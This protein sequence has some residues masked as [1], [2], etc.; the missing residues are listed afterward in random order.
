MPAT[1]AV[2]LRALACIAGLGGAATCGPVQVPRQL[3][4]AGA[5]AGRYAPAQAPKPPAPRVFPLAR[6]PGIARRLEAQGVDVYEIDLD[7]GQYLYATF[8][9]RG[10][11]VLVAV[12]GPG[13]P[14]LFEVDGP[15]GTRGKERVHLV[16]ERGGRY[17]LAVRARRTDAA[18]VYVVRLETLRPATVRD[19]RRAAAERCFYEA[20]A[21]KGV[22]PRFWEG[23]ARF[24]QAARLFRALGAG[25]R[26][27]EALYRLGRMYFDGG[28]HGEAL[29]ALQSA[30]ELFAVA[31]DP[32]RLASSD[33]SIGRCY[34]ASGRFR[35]AEQAFLRAAAEWRQA[36]EPAALAETLVNLGDLRTY[37]GMARQALAVY[38]QAAELRRLSRDAAGEAE[39]ETHLGSALRL[40]GDLDRALVELGRGLELSQ[41]VG[42][43]QRTGLLSQIGDVFIAAKEPHR[44]LACFTQALG[45]LHGD[46]DPESRAAILQ[47]LG[48]AYRLL[49]DFGQSRAAYDKALTIVQSTGNR[50]AEAMTWLNL[51][52]A[53]SS[54][55]QPRQ[56]S[57]CYQHALWL[58]RQTGYRQAEALAL[59]GIATA[60]RDTG[61]PI[62]AVGHG[63]AALRL[64][65][66]LRAAASRPDLQ[67]TYLAINENY[68]GFL[69][70]TLMQLHRIMPG[71]GYELRAFQCSEQWR[72]RGLLDALVARRE[73]CRLP[74]AAA[75]QLDAERRRLNL[76]I[77]GKDLELRRPRA[78]AAGAAEVERQLRALWDRTQDVEEL[79]RQ[80]AP[81]HGSIPA[82]LA[83][84]R[85]KLLDD[86]TVLL[87]YY[88]GTSKSYLWAA[89]SDSIAGFELPA[90]GDL[91]S[92]AL[93]TYD[94]LSQ[95]RQ[96][97]GKEGR[98]GPAARLSQVLL[99]QIAARL[100]DR[101]LVIVADGVL[102]YI[103]FAALPD[104]RD[105]DVPLMLHHEIVYV[106]SLAV[107]SELCAREH[108]KQEQHP[109]GLIAILADPVFGPKDERAR[110]SRVVSA[111]LDPLVA[112]LPRMPY[113]RVEADGIAAL[114]GGKGVLE[115]LGFEADRDLVTGGRL[116]RYRDLHFVTH[117]TLR[118]DHPELSGL[119]LSQLDAA[120]RAHYG[121]LRADEI[122][123][124]D[125]PVD[126][127]VLS[128]CKTAVGR[129]LAGEGMVGLPQGFMI[130]GARRVLVS[131]WNVGDRSTAEL[132]LHFYQ[133]LLVDHLG[134]GAAL[135]AAQCAMW[136][137][138]SRRAPY[139]WAGFV[140]QGD[141]R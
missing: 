10:I 81:P 134:P 62:G 69:V 83:V 68:F 14:A 136:R 124:L 121:W 41:A 116:R 82:P 131:L 71:H 120:G 126:L 115:A 79:L 36:R 91:E 132:M 78:G 30:R 110:R 7:A 32:F 138:P 48:I 77:A 70:G 86:H 35:L 128:A 139:C 42:A 46:E 45:L 57:A 11:D 98:S 133:G 75:A 99:G 84:L 113:A 58:A 25:H 26:Q 111:Q 73:R 107:L 54:M 38:R 90:R 40:L 118:T 28:R 106:P 63:D 13:S 23:V 19:R 31:G 123:A 16:A 20:L 108:D 87:E 55:Q 96:P 130:A 6:G 103:P 15:Y 80:Q 59:L 140:L 5:A 85:H 18:G 76:R 21:I 66:A 4:A 34:G 109:Q 44:A 9:Q 72:A 49:G 2:A 56:A 92:L 125:L 53:I 22:R 50:R 88:L 94:A 137:D 74:R 104:P 89:T 47:G 100:S 8:D 101:R 135:R 67:A 51:G 93:S 97:E 60:E 114:A 64:V 95:R 1:P 3:L 105:P 12:S 65:E 117:G 61:N 129:V 119:A 39:V 24:E 43:R 33:N 27:A 29:P 102:Q 52:V 127:V 17:T 112:L 122:A 37:H 141:W